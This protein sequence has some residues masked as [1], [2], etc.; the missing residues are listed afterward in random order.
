MSNRKARAGPDARLAEITSLFLAMKPSPAALMWLGCE[1]AADRYGLRD[2]LGVTLPASVRQ[3][4]R[5]RLRLVLAWAY[6]AARAERDGASEQER[7][8]AQEALHAALERFADF[9][10]RHVLPRVP[11]HAATLRDPPPLP[12]PSEEGRSVI[13]LPV[14]NPRS[15]R[16]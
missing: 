14:L 4:W 1:A 16:A 12:S 2:G 6:A 15:A 7:A 5:W 13:A 9:H 3:G 11:D 8:D 10:A